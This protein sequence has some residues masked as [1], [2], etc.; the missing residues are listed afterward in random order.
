MNHPTEMTL[1][2]LNEW[3]HLYGL[4]EESQANR[5]CLSM[6][7]LCSK[8]VICGEYPE[9]SFVNAEI[10]FAEENGIEIAYMEDLNDIHKK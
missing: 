10:K 6:L 4:I 9:T 8:M 3:G 1:S 5:D 2:P 7:T